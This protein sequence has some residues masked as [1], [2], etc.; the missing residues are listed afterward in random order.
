MNPM[1]KARRAGL[2]LALLPCCALPAWAAQTCDTSR[3]PLSTPAERFTDNGDGTL[4]DRQSGLTWMRCAL[5]QTWSGARCSGEPDAYS[6]SSAQVAARDLNGRGGY[7]GHADWRMPHIPELAMI[8]ERQC[9]D[10]RVNAALFPDTPATYFW[11]ATARR[12]KGLEGEAYLLS[13]GPE[14]AAP[15][16]KDDRHYARLVRSDPR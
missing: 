7:A 13:F 3:Y 4:T 8:V 16:N 10:P 5:G 15:R 1:T 12:G 2:L 6:W 14:G 9:A 11:T